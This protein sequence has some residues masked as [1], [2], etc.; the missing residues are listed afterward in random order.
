MG[1]WNEEDN[2]L[3]KIFKF[4]NFVESID[5]VNKIATIAEELNHH[6]DI[7]INYN[8]VRIRSTTYSAGKKI[9]SKDTELTKRIDGI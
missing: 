6:P 1:N 7:E 2:Y 8:K 9:T 4:K 5:F 3:V